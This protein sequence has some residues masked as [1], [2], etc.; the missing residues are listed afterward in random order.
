[1]PLSLTS[2]DRIAGILQYLQ[3]QD[4]PSNYFDTRAANLR[5]VSA[6]DIQS[7]AK[8]LLDPNKAVTVVAGGSSADSL[9][10]ERTKIMAFDVIETLPN[11]E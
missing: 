5:T 1:M 9:P 11:V 6:A 3:M 8:E 2:T 7:L 4:L 10:A